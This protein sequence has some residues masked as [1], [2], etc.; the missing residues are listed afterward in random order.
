MAVQKPACSQ[1]W[2]RQLGG[3]GSVCSSPASLL[4]TVSTEVQEQAEAH[5]R[6]KW[7][8]QSWSRENVQTGDFYSRPKGPTG[9]STKSMLFTWGGI[10]ASGICWYRYLRIKHLSLMKRIFKRTAF[11]NSKHITTSYRMHYWNL[12][13][14]QNYDFS[15]CLDNSKT[16][17]CL[18]CLNSR[19]RF[20]SLHSLSWLSDFAQ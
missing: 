10:T 3:Q 19:N 8:D 18:L 7:W 13:W 4:E 15:Q 6:K 20:L 9:T 16:N 2:W 17:A 11:T 14:R 5:G 1:C 12:L